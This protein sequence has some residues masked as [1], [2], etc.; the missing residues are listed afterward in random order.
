MIRRQMVGCEALMRKGQVVKFEAPA[1]RT[2]RSK[3][4]V[5]PALESDDFNQLEVL[6]QNLKSVAGQPDPAV[7]QTLR[8]G[9]L[10]KVSELLTVLRLRGTQSIS[11]D[12]LGL[13]SEAVFLAAQEVYRKSPEDHTLLLLLTAN[14]YEPGRLSMNVR[15]RLLTS[16]FAG[17]D[18]AK[19]LDD[20]TGLYNLIDEWRTG[21]FDGKLEAPMDG[22]VINKFG[23]K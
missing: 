1:N 5:E 8:Y 22:A 6:I 23:L 19:A 14:F 3:A 9:L 15:Y 20:D 16:L 12:K 2:G 17:L 18:L 10:N 21:H 13:Y 7:R 11:Q 4:S